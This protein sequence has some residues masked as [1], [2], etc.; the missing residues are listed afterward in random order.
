MSFDTAVSVVAQFTSF[1][2]AVIVVTWPASFDTAVMLF[3]PYLL[4]KL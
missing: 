3:G 2:K 4:I 1:D